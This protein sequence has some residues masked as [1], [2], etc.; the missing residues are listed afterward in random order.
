[1]RLGPFFP[2]IPLG[3]ICYLCNA[4]SSQDNESKYTNAKCQLFFVSLR[5]NGKVQGAGQIWPF[6]LVVIDSTLP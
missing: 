3:I 4:R 6:I 2:L 5:A 1:M